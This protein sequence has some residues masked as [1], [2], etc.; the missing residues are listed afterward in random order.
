MTPRAKAI[1]APRKSSEAQAAQPDKERACDRIFKAACELFYRQGIRAVG[2]E[3]I[4]EEANATKMSLYRTY[5]SK[6]ELVAEYLRSQSDLLWQK[7]DAV[8]EQHRGDPRKQL[9]AWFS[10]L[11]NHISDP[12]SRGCAMANAAVELTDP[13]H[14]GRKIIEE[15]KAELRR[16]LLRLCSEMGAR[17]PAALADGLF[18]LMEGALSSTQTLGHSGPG[19][20]VARAAEAL[21]EAHLPKA[22]IKA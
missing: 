9:S 12:N 5:P 2:V 11:N 10:G 7:W 19:S 8:L 15:H 18:L 14:P 3:T 20:S 1:E 17:E 16:R 21:I 13:D 6:D 4:A 22:A